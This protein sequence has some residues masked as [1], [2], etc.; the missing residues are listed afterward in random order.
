ME[1]GDRVLRCADCGAEFFFTV[2]E[3]RFY[4]EKG[5]KN[6]PKRCKN[7]KTKRS[8]GPVY[9]RDCFQHRRAAAAG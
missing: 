6:E 9:C 7:C 3:Q 4:A 5:F 8:Q 1:H 2:G